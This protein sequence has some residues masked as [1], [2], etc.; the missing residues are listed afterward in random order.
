MKLLAVLARRLT[1]L[2]TTIMR[3]PL[4]F[5][6]LVVLAVIQ[7]ATI[8]SGHKYG[9]MIVT[10]VFAALAFS[11]AQVCAERYA[12]SWWIRMFSIVGATLLSI[13][14]F[15]FIRHDPAFSTIVLTRTSIAIF[16][17][18][19]TFAWLP[20]LRGGCSFYTNVMILFKSIFRSLFFSIIIYGGIMLILVAV[21]TLLV[22]IGSRPYSYTGIIL[23]T[24]W[25]PT[26]FLS[27]LP[28]FHDENSAEF[29]HAAKVPKFLDLLISYVMIPTAAIYSLVLLIYMIKT[30]AIREWNENL[31]EPLILS[32]C[33]AV[34]LIYIL[35][36][37]LM[38]QSAVLF[39]NLA[40][41]LLIP[42]AMF[43]FVST[44]LIVVNQ[45][46]THTHYLVLLFCLY[47]AVSGVILSISS[48]KNR[49]TLAILAIVCSVI[50]VTPP[51]DAFTIGRTSQTA[52]L[53]MVLERNQ[54]I[55]NHQ[56]QPNPSI[57]RKDQ[58]MIA[59]SISYLEQINALHRLSYLPRN[60]DISSDFEKTFGFSPYARSNYQNFDIGTNHAVRISGYDY[61]ASLS[62]NKPGGKNHFS[63]SRMSEDG[64]VYQVSFEPTGKYGTIQ[65]TDSKESVVL[66][67][68]LAPMIDHVEKSKKNAGSDTVAVD[69]MSFEKENDKAKIK[70]IFQNL[71]VEG[72]SD[73]SFDATVY[74]LSS[75]K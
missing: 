22:Q 1:G 60:F 57:E 43:Q 62:I 5:L 49:G 40:P 74:V 24:V 41:K 21:D 71:T 10:L 35:S 63:I 53:Q 52:R 44:L 64:V 73:N 69:Q 6:L 19:I 36:N 12:Y 68:P 11:A 29:E 20:S 39:R 54:M 55:R 66:S 46:M 50:A 42:I 30:I 72:V 9:N 75:I 28:V 37:W 34:L 3:F 2:N 59:R 17:L 67:A 27:L 33:V 15:L 23:W 47:A 25:A 56:V 51:I 7:C 58:E 61:L 26:L 32:Y 18:F 4:T 8:E 70:I 48:L 38:N 45:G 13:L 31:L 14:D 16:G 65:I